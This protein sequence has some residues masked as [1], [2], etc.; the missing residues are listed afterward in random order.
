MNPNMSNAMMMGSVTPNATFE[1]N[2][3]NL[4]FVFYDQQQHVFGK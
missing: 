4:N 3:Q 2:A 1:F